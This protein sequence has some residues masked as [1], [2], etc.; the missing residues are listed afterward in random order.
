MRADR[1]ALEC[2]GAKVSFL[3]LSTLQHHKEDDSQEALP[4]MEREFASHS[5]LDEVWARGASQMTPHSSRVGNRQLRWEYGNLYTIAS[6][7]YS[8]S[9]LLLTLYYLQCTCVEPVNA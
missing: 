5:F 2:T 8:A 7:E 6:V 9:S 3:F 1:Q 4:P